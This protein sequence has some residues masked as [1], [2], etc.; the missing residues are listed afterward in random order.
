MSRYLSYVLALILVGCASSP[1]L[2]NDTR[3]MN[4][5]DQKYVPEES[6]TFIFPDT[7]VVVF[8][9][10]QDEDDSLEMGQMVYAGGAGI[11]GL[12]AQAATH[13]AIM[14]S[15][16][17]EKLTQQ[18]IEA[19]ENVKPLID[20]TNGWEMKTLLGDKHQYI[21][22]NNENNDPHTLW[23]QPTFF[24][25]QDMDVISLWTAIS[26]PHAKVKDKKKYQNLIK[27][28]APR[29]EKNALSDV[30]RLTSIMTKLLRFSVIVAKNEVTGKYADIQQQQKTYIVDEGSKKRVYRGYAIAETC[31]YR[32]IRDLRSWI[33]AYPISEYVG[34]CDLSVFEG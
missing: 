14:Q 11:I 2:H 5:L 34:N 17:N 4:A 18:Q 31:G 24:S 9:G 30:N 20:I 16:R 33:I 22:S 10:I 25:N 26:L 7:D 32:V 3:H 13:S 28:Y 27:V 12:I 21:S 19:N 8:R 1:R 23:F 6:F 15:S 29:Q